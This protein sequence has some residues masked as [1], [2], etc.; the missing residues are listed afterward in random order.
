MLKAKPKLL[1]FTE[2]NSEFAVFFYNNST[3]N[4]YRYFKANNQYLEK[5][6]NSYIF[7]QS[8]DTYVTFE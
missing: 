1:F 4:K 3:L 6:R 8:T 7:I 2:N 5:L